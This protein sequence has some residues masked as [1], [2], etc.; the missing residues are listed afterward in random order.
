[1]R[2]YHFV[3]KAGE[4]GL[5][6]DQHLARHLPE[7]VSRS[8]I[9]RAIREGAVVVAG[10]P[11]KVHYKLRRGDRI[12][13]RFRLLPAPARDLPM[14]PQDI[15][16]EVAYE[17]A[18]VLV[19]NKPPGMVT[20]PA[21]G[22][23]DGTLVNAILWHLQDVPSFEFRVSSDHPKPE[24]RN[25]KPYLP[26]AG[27]VHRLDKDTSGLLLVAKVPEAHASLSRQLKTRTMRRR[28]LAVV[29]G[30]LP[31]D[32]GTVNASIGR[33]R[34][35][36]KEMTIRHLGGRLAV[37][38]YHV[39]NRCH[40][41]RRMSNVEQPSGHSS[42]DIRHSTFAYTVV[43]VSLETGRTH[44]IRVHMAH[45]GHPVIGDTTYGKRPASFWQA[46]GVNR[47]L[48]HAYQ[49]TFQHPTSGRPVSIFAPIPEDMVPWL[50]TA[51][52]TA[53]SE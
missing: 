48:L 28:Y 8:M 20:H 3:I 31:L 35:H 29:E 4:A 22:H 39:L 50:G 27:I 32:A 14:L 43:D 45:L 30:R 40:V 15:P 9:Q 11:V 47:Q 2:T 17:D 16:L 6:L 5:R 7:S 37:T 24:T 26:R 41:E 25:P 46:L 38:H 10:R 13:A 49:L 19:V 52:L 34:T 1:M 23:W 36:R 12:T 42:L 33:H 53:I 44:Q 51:A 18:Q 21:P